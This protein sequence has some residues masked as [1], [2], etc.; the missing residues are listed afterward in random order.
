[1]KI[2]VILLVVLLLAGGGGGAYYYFVIMKA[3][4]EAAELAAAMEKEDVIEPSP[5]PI[6]PELVLDPGLEPGQYFVQMPGQ[7]LRYSPDDDGAIAKTLDIGAQVEVFESKDG[8]SRVSE[9]YEYVD[10]KMA[11]WIPNEKLEATLPEDYDQV[12]AM[13]LEGQIDESEDF[14]ELRDIF[15]VETQ[16][17]IDS[18]RCDYDDFE[19]TKGW[20]KSTD[21]AQ[22]PVYF[23][24]CGGLER[25]DK[26]YLNVDSREVFVP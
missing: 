9:Y 11:H 13:R 14:M 24:Y 6:M 1:M 10:G 21:Y 18:G 20:W 3:E 16:K 25:S 2:V 17:L 4:Q 22:Q 5:E 23:T 15:M 26:I 8:W 7:E 12:R 19:V